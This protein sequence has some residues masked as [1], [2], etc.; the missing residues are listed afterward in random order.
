MITTLVVP[1]D[2]SQFGEEAIPYAL[3]VA[4]RAKAEL[5][6]VHVHVPPTFA[7]YPD[8]YVD[9]DR[10]IRVEEELYLISKSKQIEQSE[11]FNPVVA[12]VDGRGVD[13][14]A[15]YVGKVNGSLVIMTTHGR[16]PLSRLWLGSVA[17][18]L[19]RCLPAP[20]LLVRPAG[21]PSPAAKPN[22]FRH[23]I[24]PL[25]GSSESERILK[26][27][28]ELGRLLSCTYTLFQSVP[29]VPLMGFDITGVPTGAV[30]LQLV[31]Q[32]QESAQVYLNKAAETLRSEGLTVRARVVI[33]PSAPTAI[34]DQAAEE[35]DSIIALATT[36]LSGLSRLVL[37]SVADKVIRGATVPI[38]VYRSSFQGRGKPDGK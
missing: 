24:I 29:P 30:D 31:Q 26:P 2:G 3:E 23:I 21:K 7:R 8:L 25:D 10:L 17:D 27:A 9:K 12:V 13:A 4:R 1:L 37:G 38:L 35:P 5:R 20:T 18:G 34:L 19:I 14:I 6:L 33:H 22:S 11:G 15:D 28:L 16:G 32:L 36:G